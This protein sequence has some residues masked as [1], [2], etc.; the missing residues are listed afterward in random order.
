MDLDFQYMSVQEVATELGMTDGGVRRILID[1]KLQG[2]K[3][4]RGQ[5]IIPYSAVLKFAQ[6][7][8]HTGRPRKNNPRPQGVV[9]SGT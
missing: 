3:L 9:A 2:R 5:W 6:E 4:G 1:G 7:P 8:K